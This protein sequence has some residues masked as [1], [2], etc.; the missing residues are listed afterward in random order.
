MSDYKSNEKLAQ[1]LQVAR[2]EIEKRGWFITET[3][4]EGDNRHLVCE[5]DGQRK[6]WG[7]FDRIT[8]WSEAYRAICGMEILTILRDID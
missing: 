1:V 3:F 8:C 5:K 4:G 7:M 6:A 2:S